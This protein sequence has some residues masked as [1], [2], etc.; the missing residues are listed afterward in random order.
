VPF[1]RRSLEG[2]WHIGP[3]EDAPEP[4]IDPDAR[5]VPATD[6]SARR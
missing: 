3:E 4:P 1:L 2:R 5:V 6:R